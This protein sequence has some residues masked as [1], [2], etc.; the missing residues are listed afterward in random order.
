MRRRER[1]RRGREVRGREREE[2][3]RGEREREREKLLFENS[4]TSLYC[5]MWTVNRHAC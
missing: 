2:E 1:G 3:E 5:S 4:T